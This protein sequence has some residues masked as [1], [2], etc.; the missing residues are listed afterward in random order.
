MAGDVCVGLIYIPDKS[1]IYFQY[2]DPQGNRYWVLQNAL[3]LQLDADGWL[4]F[5]TLHPVEYDALVANMDNQ[6]NVVHEVADE[7]G[8]HFIDL[9]PALQAAALTGEPTYYTYDSH[10]SIRGHQVAGETVAQYIQSTSD[11]GN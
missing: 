2:A 3:N 5:D 6:R 4:S 10:W 7:V 11:C 1:H 8:I 9:V